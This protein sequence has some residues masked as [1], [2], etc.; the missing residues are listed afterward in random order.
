MH[1]ASP[2]RMSQVIDSESQN[3]SRWTIH[4]PHDFR[5]D[6]QIIGLELPRSE[7]GGDNPCSRHPF[8][9]ILVSD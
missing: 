9:N 6:C 2:L 7:I 4:K 8:G 5:T 1:K 3:L